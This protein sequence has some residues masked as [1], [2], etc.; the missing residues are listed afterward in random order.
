M[1]VAYFPTTYNPNCETSGQVG[2]TEGIGPTLP[3]SIY[4]VKTLKQSGFP[5]SNFLQESQCLS[6]TQS[7]EKFDRTP[8]PRATSKLM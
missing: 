4:Y 7:G 3:I 6:Q 1:I 2:R 5:L 8:R